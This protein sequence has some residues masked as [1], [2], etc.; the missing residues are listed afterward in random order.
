M[1][2]QSSA[3]F[4][5]SSSACVPPGSAAAV[6]PAHPSACEVVCHAAACRIRREKPEQRLSSTLPQ[7]SQRVGL[8][9]L[10][11]RQ[12]RQRLQTAQKCSPPLVECAD[13]CLCGDFSK[14]RVPH[15][16]HV[17][18]VPLCPTCP[19]CVRVPRVPRVPSVQ[20]VPRVSRVSHSSTLVVAGSSLFS[21]AFA[22]FDSKTARLYTTPQH[23]GTRNHALTCEAISSV[24]R[25]RTTTRIVEKRSS[26]N[27]HSNHV[28]VV[29]AQPVASFLNTRSIE[30]LKRILRA[31]H[32][33]KRLPSVT[34]ARPLRSR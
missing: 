24:Q 22:R 8:P 11:P 33:H 28:Y 18:R 15:V 32:H 2:F 12:R 13:L 7:R 3:R 29:H 30:A 34:L 4:R 6:P 1:R 17:P 31:T 21:F 20:R 14:P 26:S 10:V 16:P 5:A 19:R 27:R 9:Q 25:T 23:Q